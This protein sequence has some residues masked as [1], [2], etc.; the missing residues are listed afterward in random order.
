MKGLSNISD[1]CLNLSPMGTAS[2]SYVLSVVTP[3]P[4]KD[5]PSVRVVGVVSQAGR[6]AR[7]NIL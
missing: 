7:K 1:G 6:K 2:E 3:S 5:G 4:V